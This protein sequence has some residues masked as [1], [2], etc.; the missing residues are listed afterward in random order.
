MDP[1]IIKQS[2]ANSV[3]VTNFAAILVYRHKVPSYIW[4][5]LSDYYDFTKLLH[6]LTGLELFENMYDTDL[7]IAFDGV[8]L[9]KVKETITDDVLT[10]INF[11]DLFHR[12][13]GEV[14]FTTLTNDLISIIKK[15]KNSDTSIGIDIIKNTAQMIKNPNKTATMINRE[16]AFDRICYENDR[17]I[18]IRPYYFVDSLNKIHAEHPDDKSLTLC[19]IDNTFMVKNGLGFEGCHKCVDDVLED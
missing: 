8:D 5:S 9:Y 17:R 12:V 15:K 6:D 7:G 14:T 4:M 11:Y 10:Q 3:H 1:L 13:P 19:G 18:K 16:N 2:T